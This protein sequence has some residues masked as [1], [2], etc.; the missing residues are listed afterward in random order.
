MMADLHAITVPHEPK[1][2][3]ASTQNTAALYMACGIDPDKAAIFVQSQVPA[4]AELAWLLQCYT[5][6]GWLR[7]MIQ[8][9]TKSD[10]QVRIWHAWSGLAGMQTI[11]SVPGCTHAPFCRIQSHKKVTTSLKAAVLWA[12]VATGAKLRMRHGMARSASA[13]MRA[14]WASSL[15]EHRARRSARAC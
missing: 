7:K 5:P 9:K 12:E 11:R 15:W 1:E 4:H 10:K 3:L 2:L 6:I 13:A 14:K 8:F